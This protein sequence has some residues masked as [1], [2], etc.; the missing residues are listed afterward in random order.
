MNTPASLKNNLVPY[1]VDSNNTPIDL[2]DN[3]ES[4]L[5]RKEEWSMALELA[6]TREKT[7][8]L[9]LIVVMLMKTMM[10]CVGGGMWM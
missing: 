10:H 2:K 7:V 1:S 5:T 3:I 6:E 9:R 4:S 8:E